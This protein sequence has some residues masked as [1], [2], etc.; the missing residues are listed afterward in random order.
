MAL[1]CPGEGGFTQLL[2]PGHV[3]IAE[4]ASQTPWAAGTS[5]WEW[6]LGMVARPLPEKT[7]HRDPL[8][9]E[10]LPSLSLGGSWWTRTN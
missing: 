4:A 5:G 3:P 2:D 1:A 9:Q 6:W 8:A 7:T 10:V